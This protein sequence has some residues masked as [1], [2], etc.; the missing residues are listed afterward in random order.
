MKNHHTLPL[1]V[2]TRNERLAGATL[3]LVMALFAALFVPYLSAQN[4]SPN[5]L[6]PF[7]NPAPPQGFNPVSA[8]DE[9]LRTYGF[10]PR[11][12]LTKPAYSTWVGIVSAAK[13]RVANPTMRSTGIVHRPH[14]SLGTQKGVTGTN[15]TFEN[16]SGI[17][18]T[19]SSYFTANGSNVVATFSVPTLVS[20][21]EDCSYAP[22]FTSIWTGMDGYNGTNDD[23]LQAGVNVVACTTPTY[24]AWYEWYTDGCSGS[25]DACYE[26]EVSLSISPGDTVIVSVTYYTSSPNATAFI[27]DYTTGYYVS[28]S[29]NQPSGNPG[30]SY[31]GSTA[32]W[33]VERPMVGGSIANLADYGTSFYMEGTYNSNLPGT[34]PAS[35]PD[36][37]TM[38]CPAWNPSSACPYSNTTLSYVSAFNS[39]SGQIS[40]TPTGPATSYH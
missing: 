15:Y 29:Y 7:F 2:S 22:Y 3:Q 4:V 38:V 19:D 11:P 26:T 1:R 9:D 40:F 17:G 6:Q 27:D 10:P 35:G 20:S 31:Q 36:Y 14:A 13:T 8:S 37:F 39:T 18:V 24:Y 16:W 12:A 23:V 5:T 32:E 25:S 21:V 30:S 33:V 34:G 28:V